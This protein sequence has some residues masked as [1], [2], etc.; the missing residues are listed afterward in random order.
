MIVGEGMIARAFAHFA[1]NEDVVVFAS[2][3][4]NSA[5]TDPS[6]FQR[7]HELLLHHLQQ[8]HARRLI[9]FGSCNVANPLQLSD[10][11]QHKR[12]MEE[13]VSTSGNGFVFRLPQVV[14]HTR[15]RHTLTN[16]LYDCIRQGR[17]V[18][19]WTRAQRNLIDVDDVSAIVGELLSRTE[20]PR[21]V[22]VA[23]PWSMRMGTLIELFE[24]VIGKKAVVIPV[25]RGDSF[26][27]DSRLA[28]HVAHDIG[29]D[30]GPDYPRRIIRK[31]YAN[32]DET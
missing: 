29:L 2:G 1:K 14:G 6:A 28:E 8:D 23:S 17:P 25:D 20:L 3:V 27:V 7:E 4:S 31:Y 32:A 30:F 9:Y 16:H 24:E 22:S 26:E 15:N 19:L 10:Y 13:L 21:V 12:A 5:E 18:S 11:F